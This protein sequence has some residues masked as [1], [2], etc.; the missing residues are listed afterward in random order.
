MIIKVGD[1]FINT[2]HLV[3]ARFVEGSGEFDVP[4]KFSYRL[5]PD[6]NL[7]VISGTDAVDANELLEKIVRDDLSWLEE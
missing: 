7:H 1:D 6:A 4:P 5:Q 3:I 2:A